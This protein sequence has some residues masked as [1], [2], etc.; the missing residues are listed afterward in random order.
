MIAALTLLFAAVGVTFVLLIR[1]LDDDAAHHLD[2][3]SPS[4]AVP[5]AGGEPHGGP[6]VPQASRPSAA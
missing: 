6:G 5:P 1:G 4:G 2:Q 3:F